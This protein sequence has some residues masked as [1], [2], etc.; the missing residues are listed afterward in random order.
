[1]FCLR[2]SEFTVGAVLLVTLAGCVSTGNAP[3]PPSGDDPETPEVADCASGAETLPSLEIP[4]G[5]TCDLIGTIIEGDLTIS[6]GAS[7]EAISIEVGGNITGQGAVEVNL[8]SVTAG[9]NIQLSGGT[10]VDITNGTVSGNVQ[11]TGN[12]EGSTDSG[13]GVSVSDMV[14][15]GDLQVSQNTGDVYISTNAVM[16]NLQCEGNNPAPT[17]E[18]NEVTGSKEGQ[19]SGL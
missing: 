8:E 11:L 19:C 4:A 7:L 2:L 12:G 14:I 10:L 15:E 13:N 5:E 16:G 18:D 1:M 3:T 6:T 9:G 17:G